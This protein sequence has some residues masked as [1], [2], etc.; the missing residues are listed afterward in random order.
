[1]SYATRLAN[2]VTR[3][4]NAEQAAKAVYGEQH[5]SRRGL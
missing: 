2:V 4:M 3:T 5:R 1:M